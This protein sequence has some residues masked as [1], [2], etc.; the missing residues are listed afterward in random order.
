MK[1][2]KYI[3]KLALMIAILCGGYLFAQKQTISKSDLPRPAQE[4]LSRHIMGKPFIYIRNAENPKDIDYTVKYNDMEI[5]FDD[6]G[7]WEEIDGKGNTI[8][9]TFLDKNIRSYIN[10]N[11]RS[12]GVTRVDRHKGKYQ[13]NLKSGVKLEFDQS[14]KF[15]K[16]E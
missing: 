10:D 5:E 3:P 16:V 8:P 9:T 2:K 13:I 14:G 7:E 12:D 4:F 15:L 1:L 6:K 11:Y